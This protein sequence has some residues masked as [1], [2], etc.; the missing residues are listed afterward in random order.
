MYEACPS[1]Q[2]RTYEPTMAS[3]PSFGLGGSTNHSLRDV[4]LAEPSQE[5]DRP[6]ASQG[7][8]IDR[9]SFCALPAPPKAHNAS[10]FGK[11]IK[12]TK[13]TAGSLITVVA[14]VRRNDVKNLSKKTSDPIQSNQIFSTRN[15]TQSNPIQPMVNSGS[16]DV[17]FDV[18]IDLCCN[19]P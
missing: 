19:F 17:I 15:W 7:I 3:P 13:H 5:V 1:I 14:L 12:R 6:I 2:R 11:T 16:H 8:E 9:R 18:T 10:V 4:G